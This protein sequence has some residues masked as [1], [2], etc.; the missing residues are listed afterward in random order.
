[1]LDTRQDAV[2]V[3]NAVALRILELDLAGHS[4]DAITDTL[5]AAHDVDKAV[6]RADVDDF[7]AVLRRGTDPAVKPVE[8]Y[9]PTTDFVVDRACAQ[10]ANSTYFLPNFRIEV[11]AEFTALTP[12]LDTF[13]RLSESVAGDATPLHVQ[14][15]EEG[16]RYPIVCDGVTLDTGFT[17]ADAA[18]K[19]VREISGLASRHN[20]WS[21]IFHA[22]AV[23]KEGVGMLIPAIGGSGKTTLSAYL[24][25]RGYQFLNDDAVPLLTDEPVLFPAPICLSIKH[26]SWPVLANDFPEMAALREFGND[27]R[28]FKYLSPRDHQICT[29]PV[30][31][32]LILLPDYS[33]NHRE[34]LLEPVPAVAVFQDIIEGGCIMDRPVDP[35]KLGG[36]V[37][38]LD[39]IACYRISYSQLADAHRVID[40]LLAN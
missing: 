19:C 31:C 15:Y 22:A 13:F 4:A 30:P 18:I 1:V 35:V 29:E 9:V 24:M 27:E 28:R 21:V 14:V 12:V 33:P 5:A 25:A 26:G 7:L 20:P 37:S 23:A 10:K 40:G 2:R 39:G 17:V 34:T 6:V 38:W 32:R 36:V 3:V 11:T 16:G 8:D